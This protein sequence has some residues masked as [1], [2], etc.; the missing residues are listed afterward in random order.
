M[1]DHLSLP[2]SD[3]A[4]WRA[5]YDKAL[6]ALGCKVVLEITDAPDII[7][8]GYSAPGSPAPSLWIGAA[9]MPV[10]APVTPEGSTSPS[11]RRAA[12]RSMP[13]ISRRWPP[14]APTT[15][16]PACG[17]TIT[18]A[19]TPRSSSTRTA[20]EF[21]AVCHLPVNPA[22]DVCASAISVWELAIKLSIG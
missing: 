18:P 12:P 9:R 11:R 5:F 19:T 8:A 17:R 16:L 2:V 22:N 3:Y 4:R 7:G 21:E 20:T 10:A 15:A 1:I 14:A 13:S 6:E